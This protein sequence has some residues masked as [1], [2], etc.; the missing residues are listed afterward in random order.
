MVVAPGEHLPR[1]SRVG[2]TVRRPQH[3]HGCRITPVRPRFQRFHI[4]LDGRELAAL[5]VETHTSQELRWRA[6]PTRDQHLAQQEPCTLRVV[7]ALTC[8]A[9]LSSFEEPAQRR[10]CHA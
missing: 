1:V 9:Y 10:R 5:K 4:S 7:G 2:H 6:R 8:G 3:R